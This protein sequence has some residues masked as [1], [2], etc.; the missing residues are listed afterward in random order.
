MHVRVAAF[1]TQGTDSHDAARVSQLVSA[2]SGDLLSFDRGQRVRSGLRIFRR[3]S[4]ARY[5]LIVMEGTGIAGGVAV[6]LARL[7]RGVPYV[8]SSGDAV[9]P[10][11]ASVLPG[12]RPLAALYERAL[13]S[14][15]EGVI[16]WSPYIT[17]R[18]LTLGARRAMTVP[19]RSLVHGA[20]SDGDTV[21]SRL[22]VP[23]E[24]IVIG[25]VGNLAWNRRRRYCYGLE[26]VD[27]IH[28][29]DRRDVVALIVGDGTGMQRLTER[30]GSLLDTHV[31][32]PGAVPPSEL[33][34]YLA[35]M[36]V[37]MLS[38]SV[39][40][41]GAFR[42][43]SKMSDYVRESIP[44]IS[45]QIPASY[46]LGG[47]WMWRLPGEAPWDVHYV[48]ALVNLLSAITKDQIGAK[49]QSMPPA[50]ALDVSEDSVVSEFLRDVVARPNQ[51]ARGEGRD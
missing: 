28:Q 47:S 23:Q 9:A 14:L 49:R 39:D 50:D 48:R 7:L 16:G 43:T 15:A 12:A 30:A 11:V 40:A 24:S 32:L 38:Q 29:L 46:D 2:L 44:V 25:I 19:H 18:A 5:D 45:T 17:G 37:A 1:A 42:Y 4:R 8:V 13:Y 34:D 3:A 22:G 20:S 33:G 51:A 31:F 21:R 10:F 26:L 41:I 27:A 6:I 35:A 36:N